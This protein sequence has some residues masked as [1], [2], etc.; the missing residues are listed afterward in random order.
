M[1]RVILA[2]VMAG[3]VAG[4][5]DGVLADVVKVMDLRCEYRINPLG[6]DER[7]PRLSWRL[8][9]T[10]RGERQTAYQI[11]AAR[12]LETL[13][14][15][16]ADLWDTGKVDSDRCIHVV[17]DGTA[18]ASRMRIYWR[19][20]VWD[21]DGKA[22]AWSEPAMWSMGLLEAD[23]WKGQWIGFDEPPAPGSE[24][25]LKDAQ[26]IWLPEGDPAKAAPVGRRWFRRRFQ[27]PA[28]CEVETARLILAADNRADIRVNGQWVGRASGF[29]AAVDLDVTPQVR[30][31]ENVL[32]V[33]VMNQGEAPNPAGLI[34]KLVIRCTDGRSLT[35]LT[36]SQWRC[37]AVAADGWDR[38][39]FAET[40]WAAARSVGP[41]GMA[42]WGKITLMASEHR[43]LPA[44]MLRREVALNGAIKRATAY[45]C[46][47]GYY[48]L[49]ING[50]K[51]GD[52]VL[53][54]GYTDYSKR[55]FY[56]TYDVADYLKTGPN[57]LGVLLGNSRFY[58]P[59]G[60]IPFETRSYG[61]P[62]MLFQL[63]VEYEDGREQVVASDGS[64]KLTTD[65]PIRANNDYDGEEYD[66]RK[67]MDGWDRPGFDDSAWQAAQLVTP[68]GGR[69]QAQ[70]NEPIK[71]TR[72]IRPK[73]IHSPAPGVFVYDMGQNM[74]GWVRLKV[75]GP[76]GTR[77]R[78]RFAETLH[79][80]GTLSVE[81]MRSAKVTD[82]YI[83]RGDG[84][85]VYEPRFTYHGFR[86]VELSGYPGT[87]DLSTIEGHVVHSGVERRGEFTCSH[88][89]INRIYHNIIWGIR[90]NLRSIPTDC[91]QRDERHGWLGDI[92]NESRAE[93]FD[94]NVA[95]FFTKWLDDI[96]EAQ[97]PEGS[98]PDVAP[99]FWPIYTDNVTWPSAY[100]IIPGHMYEQY[101]DTRILERHYP[102]MCKWV[103]YMSRFLQDGIMPRDRYG[104]WCVPPEKPELI[105]SRD[106][107]RKTAGPLL[108][109]A[110]FYHDLKLLARYARILGLPDDA[111]RYER[112]AA[113]IAQAFNAKFF[114]PATS[115]Y[116][117]G[118][119]TSC[120]LPLAFDLAPEAHRKALF[121]HLV[122]NIL[123]TNRGHLATGLIGGQW[124]M[125][126]L[127]R[128]G[129]PDVAYQLATQ[130][131]YPSWGYMVTRG[132]TT[133]WELWNGDTADPA[134]NSHNHLMLVGDLGIWLYENLA[135]IKS[136]GA[137][138]GFK[139]IIM[140]PTP[141]G[142]LRSAR[143][144]HVSLYG[145][146][147][148][149]WKVEGGLFD[150]TIRVPP[151][152]TATIYVPTSEP[153]SV[154]ENGKPADQAEGVTYLRTE[155]GR[156]VFEIGAGAYRFT[157][158]R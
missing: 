93:M 27:V 2:T 84:P 65:G 45:I 101:G 151:N 1:K 67:E 53:D 125:R 20:R 41:F 141:V 95:S 49:R 4:V 78:M 129:R 62:K 138:P 24:N 6:L 58:A 107:K 71:I 105:H 133:V 82:V 56:V 88:D 38:A 10:R 123:E 137:Q 44:R 150:W 100:V 157:A 153:E 54:P 5:G 140:R 9:S 110:Y 89:I 109:T 120:V 155:N 94:F 75:A 61:Y 59:R 19:V 147:L 113:T 118:T 97:T 121:G 134:M 36:D 114:N 156:A 16:R 154:R 146:I 139:H 102:H 79:D 99:P 13:K 63:H 98:I 136:D 43:R 42:P 127:S 21:R 70:P 17:Y 116:D 28:G 15:G 111:A 96:A 74:V 91:P 119:Q 26:W 3:F 66:A 7:K 117:N 145:P 77:V 11:Q 103:E 35:I 64:W 30:S 68:P 87:P 112:Q 143:A 60:K 57:A 80:D 126:V 124:L 144:S 34:G 12:T 132:A 14:A 46:G 130:T 158:K 72:V 40:G 52:H 122:E 50:R 83:L 85:E 128:F 32:A 106:P 152:T 48:E 142:D 37:S 81:N 51:V 33:V 47:L 8:E 18:L 135:G 73:S 22:S 69:L 92:A 55:V 104:D 131:T 149:D 148:S 90:G 115:T 108:G 76:A 86:Y 25:E 23:D 31:G 29:K 39:A